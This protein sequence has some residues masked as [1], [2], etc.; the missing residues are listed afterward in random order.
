MSTATTR[1]AIAS[2]LV[3]AVAACAGAETLRQGTGHLQA[4]GETAQGST[5]RVESWSQSLGNGRPESLLNASVISSDTRLSLVGDPR[6]PRSDL[7]GLSNFFGQDRIGRTSILVDLLAPGRKRERFTRR[8]VL[9]CVIDSSGPVEVQIWANP[10]Y[11][12][13]ELPR[14]GTMTSASSFR[15]LLAPG[16]S[17]EGVMSGAYRSLPYLREDRVRVRGVAREDSVMVRFVGASTATH[18]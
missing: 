13:G 6:G 1:V 17:V 4:Q 12:A 5:V 15:R 7:A 2:V 8:E 16:L 18:N 14:S 3:I 11:L 9:L 10:W